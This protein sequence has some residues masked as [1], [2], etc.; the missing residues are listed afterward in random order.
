MIAP[1]SV[2]TTVCTIISWGWCYRC[3]FK[4]KTGKFHVSFWR[5]GTGE[6]GGASNED[7]YVAHVEAGERVWK[8][9]RA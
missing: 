9:K 8:P 5:P 3:E 4:Q 1:T 6:G 2:Y 7:W